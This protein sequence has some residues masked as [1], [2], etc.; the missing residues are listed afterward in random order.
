M[1]EF[2]Y[3][4]RVYYEDTDVGG[5]VYYANYL[6]FAERA[7]TEWLRSLG[8]NQHQM[9]E[10]A[11][12]GFVVKQC[13]VDYHAPAMLDDM[14]TIHTHITEQRKAGFSMQ[15]RIMKNTL[16]L[17]TIDVVIICVNNAMKP[18]RIPVEVT[19]KI[20]AWQHQ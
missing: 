12:I 10:K 15:Q 1:Q 8:F 9:R 20:V 11:G 17:C 4:I 14:I 6:K 13:H 16:L 7:R 2:S 5:I 19:E 3:D 18:T